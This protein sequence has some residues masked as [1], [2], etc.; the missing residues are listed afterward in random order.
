MLDKGYYAS[1]LHM[2]SFYNLKVICVYYGR[3]KLCIVQK[4]MPPQGQNVLG[5]I[6]DLMEITG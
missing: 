1:I 4:D 2:F 6:L 5:S 3:N